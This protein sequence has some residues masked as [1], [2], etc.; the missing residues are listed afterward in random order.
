MDFDNPPQE[1]MAIFANWLRDAEAAE[2]SDANAMTLATVDSEGLP[3]VRVVLL[4]GYDARGFVFYTNLQSQKGQEIEASGR[5]ALNF[6]WKSLARQVRIRGTIETVS[7]AE[8]DTY[9]HSRARQSQL[10][11]WASAQSRPLADRATLEMAYQQFDEK[12]QGV[13]EIPR[14]PHWS[15]RRVVPASIE[16]WQDG[17][18]RL[19]DRIVYN[20]TSEGW[21]RG[22]LYP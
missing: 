10:G 22:R 13:S 18:F 7:E 6:H 15:G 1:P 5:A 16:F 21:T 14:P 9:Y 4:K 19:H 17:A 2:I 11:A 20:R 8:A 12:Y 3:N